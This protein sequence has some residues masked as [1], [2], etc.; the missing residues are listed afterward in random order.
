MDP[1]SAAEQDG[2]FHSLLSISYHL[3]TVPFDES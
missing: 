1:R 2:L 3:P